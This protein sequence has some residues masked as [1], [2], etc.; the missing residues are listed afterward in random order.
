LEPFQRSKVK[1][2]RV[3]GR[4]TLRERYMVE[5]RR[6]IAGAARPSRIHRVAYPLQGGIDWRA[7]GS[8]LQRHCVAWVCCIPESCPGV[9]LRDGERLRHST[10]GRQL[11]WKRSQPERRVSRI[12]EAEVGMVE[13]IYQ[14]HAEVDA[15]PT[16]LSPKNGHGKSF[17]SEKSKY[18]CRGALMLSERG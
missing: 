15:P 12:V 4:K 14:I 2:Q 3:S 8:G 6:Q 18:S 10:L 11:N 7:R 13:G 16:F 5:S 1:R 9:V 17:D